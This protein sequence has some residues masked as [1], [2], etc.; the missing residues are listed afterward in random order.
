LLSLHHT[1]VR[2]KEEKKGKKRHRSTK[3]RGRAQLFFDLTGAGRADQS[4]EA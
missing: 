1:I 2:N 3:I 4:E